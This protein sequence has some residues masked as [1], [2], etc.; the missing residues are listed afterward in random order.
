MAVWI[1]YLQWMH[2]NGF[3]TRQ[4]P[5][6]GNMTNIVEMD[7]ILARDEHGNPTEPETGPKRT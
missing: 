5:I 4:E 6:L 3:G 7:A 2:D 1:G